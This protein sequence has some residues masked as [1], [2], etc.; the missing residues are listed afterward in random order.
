MTNDVRIRHRSR[1]QRAAAPDHA[2][3]TRQPPEHPSDSHEVGYGKPPK[4]T[5]FKPGR[6]GNPKGRP[7]GRKNFQTEL[8]EE[9]H[10][11]IAVREGGRRRIVS[12]QRAMLKTLTAK[13]L[14]GDAR[15]AALIVNGQDFGTGSPITT[16]VTAW[17]IFVALGVS[18][19]IGLFSGIYPAFRASRLDPIEALRAE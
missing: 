3:E 15:A 9:L 1:P 12:K 10:E 5:R 11:S 13:A 18:V 8:L 14:Q 17:G 2:P 6:S 19:M 4:N 7:K 16:V